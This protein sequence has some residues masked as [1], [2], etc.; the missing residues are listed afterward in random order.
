MISK[1]QWLWQQLTEKLWLRA[2]LFAVAGIAAA[3]LAL[4]AKQL[5]PSEVSLTLGA[6]AVEP[7]LTIIASSML[8]VTTFSLNIM[9]NAY[10][11]ASTS[12]TPRATQVLL[13]D[14]TSQNV[15]GTFIGAFLYALVAIIALSTDAY[16]SSGRFLLF[17]VTLVVISLVIM[18]LLRWIAH[19]TRFGLVVL[20]EIASRALSPA[21]ND[22]GT[23]IEIIGRQ[24]RLLSCFRADSGRIDM[25]PRCPRVLVPELTAA[26]LMDDAFAP[27]IRDAGSNVEVRIRLQKALTQL[28]DYFDV[29]WHEAIEQQQQY[30]LSYAKHTLT[31][32][33][34]ERL[35]KNY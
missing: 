13:Q 32:I 15:L 3:L 12:V 2:S 18:A 27:I 19:L 28:H 25:Q 9:V 34:W 5:L 20:T 22:P 26:D 29:T 14:Q 17:I 24:V 4:F 31:E 10:Q 23:A 11:A 35:T 21:V 30:A 33:D 8:A 7:V 16:D 1:W 6:D